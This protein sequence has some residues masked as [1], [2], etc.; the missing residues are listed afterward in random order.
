M[1]S[2]TEG[3]RVDRSCLGARA[4]ARCAGIGMDLGDNR[5]DIVRTG[6]EGAGYLVEMALASGRFPQ[7]AENRLW[8]RGPAAANQ[9]SHVESV[10]H[11]DP[12]SHAFAVAAA[13]CT[14]GS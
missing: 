10:G 6:R 12:N 7:S 8:H 1:L 5:A 2:K 11:L 4:T 13:G 9:R 14:A 3:K